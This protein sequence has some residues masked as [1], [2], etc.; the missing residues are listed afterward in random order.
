MRTALSPLHR[1]P[2]Q[3]LHDRGV[4]PDRRH[5]SLVFVRERL[6][7]LA[8]DA[9]RDRRA[10]VLSRLECDRAELRE[11]LL[12]LRVGDRGDVA[13]DVDA[14]V[15]GELELGTDADPVASCSSIPSDWTRLL[16]W[17]PAPH[18]RV[19]AGMTSPEASVTRVGET[20]CTRAPVT[21]STVR[22][23]SASRVYSRRFGLNIAKISS[24]ASTSTMRFLL[25]QARIVLDEVVTVELGEGSRRLHA[26]RPA[27]H[28]DDRQ[29]SVVDEALV[30]VRCLPAGEDVV[31]E[32]HR[33][34]QRVHGERASAAP[35]VP[36]KFTS[37][38]SARTR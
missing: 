32:P 21:T 35:S 17:R 25:R 31:L 33:V 9:A 36:K 38:P 16:P 18:T 13:H 30:L 34:G 29:S 6:R 22:F 5:R 28:H 8:R 15:V 37:A 27:P 24:P 2:A 10:D 26:C 23:S 1:L 20:D 12:L 14:R 3:H 19:C 7:R 11:H 4:A